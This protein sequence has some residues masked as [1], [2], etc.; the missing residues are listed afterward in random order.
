[1]E[2]ISI[3]VQFVS[4]YGKKNYGSKINIWVTDLFKRSSC[5]LFQDSGT[6]EGFQVGAGVRIMLK[7]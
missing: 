2:Q 3:F 1:M 4:V 5:L 7:S 6:K